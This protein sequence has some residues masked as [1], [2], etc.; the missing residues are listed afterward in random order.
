MGLKDEISFV[1][2]NKGCIDTDKV[3]VD[4]IMV[5]TEYDHSNIALRSM[6]LEEVN[7]RVKN[8]IIDALHQVYDLG[9]CVCRVRILDS[10]ILLKMR[11]LGM[12]VP[13]YCTVLHNVNGD[14]QVWRIVALDDVLGEQVFDKLKLWDA[15]GMRSIFAYKD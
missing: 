11:M 14:D 4:Y 6:W 3:H 7:S 15:W 10:E 1:V 8:I 13:N 9:M 2:E 5:D 12:P